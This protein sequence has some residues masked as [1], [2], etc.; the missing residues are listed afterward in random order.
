MDPDGAPDGARVPFEA[1]RKSSQWSAL[2]RAHAQ[3]VADDTAIDA[4]FRTVCRSR[5]WDEELEREYV[6]Y[7]DEHYIPTLLSLRGLDDAAYA[8]AP[9]A[10]LVND[11]GTPMQ[12]VVASVERVASLIKDATELARTQSAGLREKAE[13]VDRLDQSMQQ[14]AAL[15][16]EGA[17]A[18]ESLKAQASRL[19]ELV[20]RFKTR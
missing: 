4:I 17:A 2:V 18:A 19:N 14:N 6:C 12:D 3:V 13:S 1:W 11:A 5:E 10:S 8:R 20:G 9:D 15:V 7:S 16:E